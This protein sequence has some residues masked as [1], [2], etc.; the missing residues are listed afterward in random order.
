MAIELNREARKEAVADV[1][2]RLQMRVQELD[3]E[4]DEDEFA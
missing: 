3:I 1:Q 4:I 2:E